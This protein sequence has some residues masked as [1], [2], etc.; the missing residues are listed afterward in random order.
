MFVAAI[1]VK[2]HASMIL[3][4]VAEVKGESVCS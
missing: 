3:D 1:P 4:A 2:G